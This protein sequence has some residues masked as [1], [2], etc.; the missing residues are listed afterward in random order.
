MS[1]LAGT[2]HRPTHVSG[3]VLAGLLALA[4]LIGA[5]ALGALAVRLPT[6]AAPA[7]IPVVRTEPAAILARLYSPYLQHLAATAGWYA[8]AAPFERSGRAYT[9]AAVSSNP[10]LVRIAVSGRWN[11]APIRT[12]SAAILAGLESEYLRGV[13]TAGRWYA[14]SRL[15]DPNLLYSD[16]LREISAD[17]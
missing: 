12:D 14:P 4:M 15:V 13:A 8:E 16:H 5:V 7:V 1:H 6:P 17:W 3:G 11:L 9:M 10:H 2:F